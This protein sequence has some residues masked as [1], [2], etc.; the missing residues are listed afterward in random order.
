[1]EE[2]E[3]EL[4]QAASEWMGSSVASKGIWYYWIRRQLRGSTS[5]L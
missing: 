1:M 2:M 3:M 4:E 5:L